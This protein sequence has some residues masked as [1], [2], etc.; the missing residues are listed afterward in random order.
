MSATTPTYE[1]IR[2]ENGARQFC[3][4][5]LERGIDTHT[6]VTTYTTLV[7]PA[8]APNGL[9]V[10]EKRAERRFHFCDE[11]PAPACYNCGA[12]ASEAKSFRVPGVSCAVCGA[13]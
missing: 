12:D 3:R 2:T 11:H 9:L 8:D 13:R 10:G 5:A 7:Y 1:V 4:G 6:A